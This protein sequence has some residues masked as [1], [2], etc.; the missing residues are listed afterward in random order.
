MRRLMSFGRMKKTQE[1]ESADLKTLLNRKYPWYQ[2]L[3]WWFLRL[4]RKPGEGHQAVRFFFQ[5]GFRGYADI[6]WWNL[7]DYLSE[8]IP[9]ALR[10]IRDGHGY[11]GRGEA[12]TPEKWRKI[13]NKMIKGFEAYK[14]KDNLRADKNYLKRWEKLDKEQKE[15][16]REFIK[17]YDSLWD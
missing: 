3:Y 13:L 16:M 14:E 4:L 1:T 15:G 6:D 9:G 7:N 10:K 17:W 5:R 12:D 2:E 11:P 8:W